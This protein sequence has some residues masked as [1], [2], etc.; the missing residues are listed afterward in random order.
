VGFK[1]SIGLG[2]ALMLV[3]VGQK[4]K[5]NREDYQYWDKRGVEGS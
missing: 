5:V 2:I 3:S 1:L 4:A